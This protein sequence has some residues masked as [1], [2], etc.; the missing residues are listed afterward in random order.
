M[1]VCA[2]RAGVRNHQAAVATQ[3][4]A[5]PTYL[6]HLRHAVFSFIPVTV[7]MCEG[8]GQVRF[9]RQQADA[10]LMRAFKCIACEMQAGQHVCDC[11]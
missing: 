10:L 5:V 4:N 1:H 11:Q 3:I 2:C 7:I 6:S 9:R 8:S